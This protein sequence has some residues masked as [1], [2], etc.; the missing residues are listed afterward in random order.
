[1]RLRRTDRSFLTQIPVLED[2]PVDRSGE[3]LRP[4]IDQAIA[5][6][7]RTPSPGANWCRQEGRYH[8]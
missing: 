6:D 5:V 7:R 1:M 4:G 2:E 8:G 3:D